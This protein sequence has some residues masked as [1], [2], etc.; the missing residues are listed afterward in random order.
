MSILA[1]PT[2]NKMISVAPSSPDVTPID[3]FVNDVQGKKPEAKA[4]QPA[5]GNQKTLKYEKITLNNCKAPATIHLA[6][7]PS[8]VERHPVILMLGSLKPNQLPEWSKNLVNEGY[9]L[10]AFTVDHP[11]DPNPDRRPTWLFFDQR[12]AHSYVLGGYRAAGD[13]K[14]VI[15]YLIQR[16]DVHAQKIG[17]VG[18]ST[19]GILGLAAAT[20][21]PR[22]AA[23]VAFVSTGAYRQWIDSW[24]YNK[25][26]KGKT[27]EIWPETEK[28]LKYDPILHVNKLFPTAVLMVSGS[29]DKI[30]DPRTARSFVNAAKPFYKSDPNR[31]RL[32][33]Y[34][35]VGHNLPTDVVRMYVEHWF[36]LFMHPTQSPPP[37]LRQSANLKESVDHTK[38]NAAQH[39]DIIK[40]E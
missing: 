21:E 33:I 27:K 12:F 24:H 14:C 5:I 17:W 13:T 10:A 8:A 37:I 1:G 39:E 30:V 35:N 38:I 11:P 19:T 20:R 40:A 4:T 9:M 25:L 32:V 7:K 26:W 36:R 22:L 15:D 29:D 28:L 18:S 2:E 34:E 16:G 3:E 31:L 23:I 6:Y